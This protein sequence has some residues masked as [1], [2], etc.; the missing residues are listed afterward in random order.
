LAL[1][2]GEWLASRP[3]RFIPSESV[4]G[5]HWARGWLDSRAGLQ[6]EAK[7]NISALLEIEHRSSGPQPVTLLTGLLRI[8]LLKLILKKMG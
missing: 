3:C 1:H 4:V 2:G 6:A 7:E 8:F 5:T